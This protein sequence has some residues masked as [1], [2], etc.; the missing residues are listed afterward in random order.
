[1][2]SDFG[3]ALFRPEKNRG[4]NWDNGCE[5]QSVVTLAAVEGGHLEVLQWLLLEAGGCWEPDLCRSK[6]KRSK[7]QDI[8]V[9]IEENAEKFPVGTGIFCY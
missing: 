3:L 8:S 1:M 9:W 6:A 4:G 2:V 7:F 5:M